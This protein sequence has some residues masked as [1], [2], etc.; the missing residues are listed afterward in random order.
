MP[1]VLSVEM[2]SFKSFAQ[3]VKLTFP[4]GLVAIVGPNG[5]GKSN[6][7][8][9]ICFVLGKTSKKEMR[10][11]RLSHLIFNGGKSKKPAEFAK[12][13]LNLD[14]SKKEFPY[15]GKVF[16]ISRTV[17]K[18][19][20][21]TFRINGNRCTLAEVRNALVSAN[22]D[23]DGFNIIMQGEIAKFADLPSVERRRVIEEIA[24]ISVYEQKKR[25]TFLELEKVEDHIKEGE[26]AL[27]E[28]KKYLDE[29]NVQRVQ[30]EKFLAKK[31]ALERTKAMLIV[32]RVHNKVAEEKDI[33][34]KLELKKKSIDKVKKVLD[35][36]QTTLDKRT[37]EMQV[38]EK[39]MDEAGEGERVRLESEISQIQTK[40]NDIDV[41]VKSHETEMERMKN[42]VKQ[43][44]IDMLENG[45]VLESL[46]SKEIRLN[47][48]IESL[49]SSL[50]GQKAALK[51]K[52]SSNYIKLKS[53]LLSLEAERSKISSE[54]ERVDESLKRL[55]ELEEL[56]DELIDNERQLKLVNRDIDNNL[57]ATSQHRNKL[58][59][60]DNYLSKLKLESAKLSERN[61]LLSDSDGPIRWV[62]KQEFK[63][64]LG[65][66]SHSIKT[67]NHLLNDIICR[68]DGIIVENSAIALKIIEQLKKDKVGVVRFFIANV[69]SGES[70]V[71]H[72][73]ECDNSF[74]PLFNSIFKDLFEE[75]DK[76][77]DS[78]SITGGF[79]TKGPAEM[80]GEYESSIVEIK[81]Y[82]AHKKQ[83]EKEC[84][85][86][87]FRSASLT[88]KRLGII[89]LIS[90]IRGRIN[91][92][93]RVIDSTDRSK[94]E[95]IVSSLRK[96]EVEKA[97]VERQM[98]KTD[99]VSEESLD[100][101]RENVE[102]LE[103]SV[104]KL[105]SEL[106]SIQTRMNNVILRDMEQFG[107][108]KDSIS[109]DIVRFQK[110]LKDAKG[111]SK[112]LAAELEKKKREKD[113]FYKKL[114]MHFKKREVLSRKL[115]A[116]EN[117]RVKMENRLETNERD[118]Q[119]FEVKKA[120]VAAQLAGLRERAQDYKDLDVPLTRKDER[121]LE[122]EI[123]Q[124]D[125]EVDSFGAVNMKAL[126]THRQIETEFNDLRSKTQM[127]RDERDKILNMINEIEG[128]KK[129]S[130]MQTFKAIQ[131]NL[132]SVFSML[133]PGGSARMI[134]ENED[135][136]FE[137]GIEVMARP[138]GKKMTT[139]KALSGGE[140]TL[141]ALA[142]I[143]AI[144]EFQPAPF[145]LLD[146]IDAALDK[147]NSG[148]LAELLEQY[149]KK[150]QFIIISHN[151]E[152]ISNSDYMYGVSMRADG[153][154]QVVSIKLPK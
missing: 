57:E 89:G 26:I 20:T 128:K 143:F 86:L 130:F 37:A 73:F 72:L 135:E 137:G 31:Q 6:I 69:K 80:K 131:K 44:N 94:R 146:E 123:R 30:A 50:K 96:I 22:I 149:S 75:G 139:I 100:A 129:H 115:L 23:P 9:S 119:E 116:L 63:G 42:R 35:E 136:P 21:S 107:K 93:E 151:D 132:N 88:E 14:N 111:T 29:L 58:D 10:A 82:S 11:E 77:R 65:R 68:L 3:K 92:M 18:D 150:A 144:Q 142:F 113:G 127:L 154:S 108:I 152:V 4:K 134:L 33:V 66:L 36:L 101:D 52:S 62:L 15:S 8:D 27:A 70:K 7:T 47:S 12:V 120:E 104:S 138:L 55:P 34:E 109:R 32:K 54:L 59:E 78:V 53:K 76:I 99:M 140:K 83:I 121:E 112:I 118:I 97:D 38:M 85:E 87:E 1:R 126:E 67:N 102:N 41:L 122:V 114:Q 56:R 19:G 13:V 5:S 133:S 153:T 46:K 71:S 28:K 81:K 124:L 2:Q 48:E 74:N 17:D 145:Y 64:V 39:K 24:G 125:R 79:R 117:R 60:I 95:T 49:K 103:E 84:D 141:L 105:N 91:E 16:Q 51:Q 90:E 25:K 61:S 110:E 40:I 147:A 43:I 45:E 98:S 106:V 148:K